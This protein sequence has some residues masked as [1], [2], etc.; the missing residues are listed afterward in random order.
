RLCTARSLEE[1]FRILDRELTGR[2]ASATPSREEVAFALR[3]LLVRNARID[4][5]AAEVELSHRRF[6]QLF[7]AAV[8]V[9]PKVFS[10]VG[11]FQRALTLAKQEP[12]PA[13]SDLAFA[14]GYA[15]QPHLI[16]EFVSL[17]GLSPLEL[18]QRSAAV[19]GHHAALARG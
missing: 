4:R 9:A 8:G 12:E 18:L 16:R 3:R 15:D 11:R 19:E 6:I 7:A 10:R 5:V 2:L 14:C 1:R 13:W 17:A